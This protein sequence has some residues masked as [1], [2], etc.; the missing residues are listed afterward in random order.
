MRQLNWKINQRAILLG[1][2]PFIK[3]YWS[4]LLLIT[5]IEPDG[6]LETCLHVALSKYKYCILAINMTGKYLSYCSLDKQLEIC[7][8]LSKYG[9]YTRRLDNAIDDI[10]NIP[11]I[12]DIYSAGKRRDHYN[13]KSYRFLDNVYSQ[14]VNTKTI[15]LGS[16]G[17]SAKFIRVYEKPE[18]GSVRW[19][20]E[21]T[22]GLAKGIFSNNIDYY[23]N[24]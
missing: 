20:L 19:E 3:Q 10:S 18:L 14:R 17:N 22:K 5:K 2:Q 8:L 23:N 24:S 16:R 11:L 15:Y 9:G 12:T 1:I 4:I 21:A 7:Y 6:D 13:F